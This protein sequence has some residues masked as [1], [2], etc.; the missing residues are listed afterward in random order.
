MTLKSTILGNFNFE[1]Q[2]IDKTPKVMLQVWRT[3][4]YEPWYS[5]KLINQEI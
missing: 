3:K 4:C 1:N 2:P 5:L